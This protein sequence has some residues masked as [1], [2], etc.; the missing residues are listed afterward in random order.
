[1]ESSVQKLFESGLLGVLLAIALFVI[2]F[3]YK[4]VRNLQ[5]KRIE[6]MRQ[7]R[8]LIVAPMN[9][10]KQTVDLILASMQNG[11]GGNHK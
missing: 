4:E 9:A 5:D 1:M 8:D 7:A 3:L 2:G 6:D 10:V 11:N